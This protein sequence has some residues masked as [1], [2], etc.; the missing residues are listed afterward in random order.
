MIYLAGYADLIKTKKYFQWGQ[1]SIG[2]NEVN[3]SVWD[4]FL[5]AFSIKYGW[6]TLIDVKADE[7]CG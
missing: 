4:I 5:I 1:I 6:R 7:L 3:C 2:L